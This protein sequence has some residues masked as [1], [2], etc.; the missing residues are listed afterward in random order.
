M[1]LNNTQLFPSFHSNYEII[2][3][4]LLATKSKCKVPEHLALTTWSGSQ[5]DN[6]PG[7]K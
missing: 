7:N 1:L 5:K 3:L 4:K 2:I 6:K